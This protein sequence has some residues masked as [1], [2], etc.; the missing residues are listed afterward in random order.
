GLEGGKAGGIAVL[1]GQ[2][3]ELGLGPQL[4]DAGGGVGPGSVGE[5]KVDQHEVRLELDRARKRFRDGARLSDH[6]HVRLV[7]DERGQTIG[8]D[9]VVF[10]D[11]HSGCVGLQACSLDSDTCSQ[12]S[13][14]VS[15][16][17]SCF[18]V[19]LSPASSARSST[20]SMPRCSV[21]WLLSL[22]T[23]ARSL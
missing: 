23:H 15:C 22:K 4:P 16:S 2:E 1:P 17:G 11:Q 19:F 12:N 20:A 13:T 8:H 18:T 3:D 5:P 9:L 21:M 6:V 7:V 14:V 10:D